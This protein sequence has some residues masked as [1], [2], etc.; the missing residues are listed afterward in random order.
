M[1]PGVRL[2]DP[3][4]PLIV[5]REEKPVLASG[6]IGVGLHDATFLG[7]VNILDYGLNPKEAAEAPFFMCPEWMSS[8][9]TGQIITFGNFRDAILDEVRSR[10][11][12]L[13]Q[14]PKEK[15]SRYRG[16]WIC[17]T[18]NPETGV[19]LGCISPYILNGHAE[20]Y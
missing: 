11:Q 18:S 12:D 14:L 7:L 16:I 1:G 10:G 5:M 13:K 6:S 3:T 8:E 9:L 15:Q 2:P 19:Y 17:L 20:G 4:N